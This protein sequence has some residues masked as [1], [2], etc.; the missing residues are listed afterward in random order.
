MNRGITLVEILVV[1]VILLFVVSALYNTFSFQRRV[2]FRESTLIDLQETGQL[3]L[4]L[5]AHDLMMAGYGVNKKLALYIYDGG[6][7]SSD[8][9]F[10]NDWTFLDEDELLGGIWGQTKILAGAGTSLITLDTLNIDKDGRQEF[11]GGV[12]QFVI[13]DTTSFNKK[14]AK[15]SSIDNNTKTL[16]LDMSLD[17]NYLVPAICYEIDNNILKKSSRDTGG[18]QPIANNV[19]DLQISYQ[20]IEGNWYCTNATSNC[21]MNPF[22]PEKIAL[23]KVSI[24]VKTDKRTSISSNPWPLENRSDGPYDPNYSYRTYSVEIA[25]RNLIYNR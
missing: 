8:K 18:R 5:I 14:V 21:P 20:D 19:V 4:N 23:V 12:S 15:I 25:P 24:V 16:S 9:L 7:N 10:I 2:K 1:I 6:S 17:G 22:N 11:K 3:V 13:S